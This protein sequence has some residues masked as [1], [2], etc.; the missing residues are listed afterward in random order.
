MTPDLNNNAIALD[1]VLQ[2]YDILL[3]YLQRPAVLLQ[4]ALFI[5]T[6]IIAY[7]IEA[8]LVT[9]LRRRNYEPLAIISTGL[10]PVIA[11]FT[12]YVFRELLTSLSYPVGL[13]SA[14]LGLLWIFFVYFVVITSL[15]YFFGQDRIQPI[16]RRLILPV[17]ILFVLSQV[18]SS[19]FDLGQLGNI[20]LITLGGFNVT[21]ARLLG[22]GLSIYFVFSISSI[23]QQL[24]ETFV[25]PNLTVDVGTSNAILT[26]TRYAIITLGLLISFTLLGLD[27]SSLA[28]IGGGLSIGIGFGLQQIISNFLSGILLLFEQS[29]RPGDVVDVDG[30]LGIVTQLSIRSTTVRTFSNIDVVIPNE[31]FLTESVKNYSKSPNVRGKIEIGVGYDSDPKEVRRLLKEI[32]SSHETVLKDPEPAVFF[33]NFGASSLDFLVIFWVEDFSDW[34][35]TETDLR[36]MIWQAFKTHNIEIPFPQR[37]LHV[38]TFPDWIQPSAEVKNPD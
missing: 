38:R 9:Q 31:R 23:L 14:T 30:Q 21:L 17:V 35:G 16:H 34:Y 20:Q 10:F 3:G 33:V 25:V 24:I 4:V 13:M 12:N 2:Q 32:V 26:I 8:I 11:I 6:L 28:L 27:L 36:M 1:T 22:F 29:L 18:F 37:D 19:V 15:Y 5:F 7:G